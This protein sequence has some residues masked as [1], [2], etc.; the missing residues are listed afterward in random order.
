MILLDGLA[1]S[2]KIKT[3]IYEEVFKLKNNGKRAPHLAAIIVGNNSASI[4]YINNKIKA[5]KQVGFESTI[6]NL[7][8]KSSE[9]T[10][11]EKIYELN[12][13][14]IID[15]FIVQLPLPKHL[16]EKKILMSISPDK[17]VD[18]FHPLNVGK[19]VL[20]LPTLLPATPYGIMELLDRYSIETSG[21][22]VLII[23]RSHIV[24]RPIS[25]LLSQKKK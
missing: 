2:S 14:P 19:M 6:I 11:L 15:G 8:E 5:C 9:K 16:D 1:T 3:E 17:D 20:E 22:Q 10:L 12:S 23:G 18:G 21:K 4:T 13:N 7:P 25:I 24:G